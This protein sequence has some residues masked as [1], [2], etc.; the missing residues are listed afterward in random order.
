MSFEEGQAFAKLHS[1]DFVEV[2][3]KTAM[4]VE[5]VFLKTSMQILE[6]INNGNVDPKNENFGIK[7]GTE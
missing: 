3:A 5:E 1:I 4:N 2:S 6:K 7:V